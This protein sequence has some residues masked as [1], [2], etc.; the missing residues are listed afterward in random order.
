[1][2]L[3]HRMQDVRTDGI[4]ID[5][6]YHGYVITQTDFSRNKFQWGSRGHLSHEE[7]LAAAWEMAHKDGWKPAKWWQFW[8]WTDSK[9]PKPAASF[10]NLDEA[11]AYLDTLLQPKKESV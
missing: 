3:S 9:P 7:A 10:T 11:N 6:T 4:Q 8:R 5:C 1:M 2:I